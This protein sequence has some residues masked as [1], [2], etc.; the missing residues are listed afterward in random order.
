MFKFRY[1]VN[2]RMQIYYGNAVNYCVKYGISLDKIEAMSTNRFLEMI[3]QINTKKLTEGSKKGQ[4]IL[5]ESLI[6]R[7]WRARL[8]AL[9]RILEGMK[10]ET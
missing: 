8:K 9:K 4:I 3:W 6:K 7:K 5:L 2:G 1:V 10:N